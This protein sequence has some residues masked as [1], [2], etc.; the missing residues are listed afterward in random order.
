MA[1]KQVRQNQQATTSGPMTVGLRN[2]IDGLKRPF[3]AFVNSFQ[4]I[5]TTRAELA[6][7]FM[8]VFGTW[9]AETGKPFVDFVRAL[10]PTVPADRAG[11]RGHKS[12]QAADYLRRLV[13]RR[14]TGPNRRAARPLRNNVA[15]MARLL[16][17]ILPLISN[18]DVVWRA[19]NEELGLN[20]RQVTALKQRT[21]AE[22][23]LM[24][25]R[26]A[27]PMSATVVHVEPAEQ[28]QAA[29]A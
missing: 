8:Q 23:P 13:A 11:Y 5:T 9:Q 12:Y 25:L 7:K 16:K 2:K 19:M 27:R 14:D 1:K 29:T 24:K 21:E 22:E 15:I 26:G 20:N 6:P 3:T 18:A 4:S 17:T 28:P 10:D